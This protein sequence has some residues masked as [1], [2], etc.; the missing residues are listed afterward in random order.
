[1][2]KGSERSGDT[3]LTHIQQAKIL[4]KALIEIEQAPQSYKEI[5]PLN[6]RE[7]TV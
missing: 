1:M 5:H 2:P 6:Y 3:L 4:H 7:G